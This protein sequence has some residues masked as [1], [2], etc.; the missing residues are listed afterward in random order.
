M[1]RGKSSRRSQA[2]RRR[3]V[4][5]QPLNIDTVP[6]A[7]PERRGTGYRH[8]VQ[9]WPI[10]ALTGRR[11]KLVLP[12]ESPA[13]NKFLL[14]VGD[15]HLRSLVDGFVK[16]PEG[17]LS[18]GFMSTPGASATELR[19]EL[20]NGTVT[21][22]PDLVCLLAPSN[23]LTASRTFGEAGVDFAKLLHSACNLFPEVVVLDFPPHLT[24]D[25]DHQKLMREEFHRV[26][27]RMGV[28]YL[29][30]A[31]HFPLDCPGIWTSPPRFCPRIFLK[32][33]VIMPRRSNPFEWTVVGQ[34]KKT[35][36][37]E[38]VEQECSIPLNPVWFSSAVM[39]AMDAVVPSHLSSPVKS[40]DAKRTKR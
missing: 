18:F 31:E 2:A 3:M 27:A 15:S 32:G 11:H 37:P 40:S 21:P 30:T 1:P 16:M 9:E 12:A 5:R 13:G 6:P 10:S 25:A 17:R 14:V 22:T 23:N 34:G 36:Q 29:S 26:A 7:S 35:H 33:E 8:A 28:K 19:T 4:E 38:E 20:L 24:A 39:D